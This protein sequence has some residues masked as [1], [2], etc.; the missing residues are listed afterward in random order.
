MPVPQGTAGVVN[1]VNHIPHESDEEPLSEIGWMVLPEFQ[2]RGLAKRAVRTV[3]EQ[4]RDQSRWGVVH[5]FP[6]RANAAPNAICRTLGFEYI[7]EVEMPFGAR[8]TSRHHWRIS[9][10]RDLV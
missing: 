6:A 7:E 3:L 2:R 9:P 10:Q 8:V 1:E 5:A 4:A